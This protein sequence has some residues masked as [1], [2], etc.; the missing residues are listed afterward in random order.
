MKAFFS[1]LHWTLP[2]TVKLPPVLASLLFAG[3]DFKPV[4]PI[5]GREH[6]STIAKF[7]NSHPYTLLRL[8]AL[9]IKMFQST[10]DL[11][12]QMIYL[13]A[14]HRQRE[15]GGLPRRKRRRDL[16]G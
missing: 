2:A 9:L 4:P 7:T 3:S 15:A 1:L 14:I 6:H 16:K 12:C 10:F 8:T 11:I 13:A 5:S